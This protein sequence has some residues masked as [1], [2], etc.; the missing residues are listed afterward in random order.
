VG[1]IGFLSRG[2]EQE[3][4]PHPLDGEGRAARLW[5]SG[6]GCLPPRPGRPDLCCVTLRSLLADTYLS[7]YLLPRYVVYI[8][9]A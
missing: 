1:T 4:T 8:S 2:Q 7:T 9:T 3:Q 6:T 5:L